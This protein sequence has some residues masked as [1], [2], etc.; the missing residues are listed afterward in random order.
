MGLVGSLFRWDEVEEEVVIPE[1]DERKGR[2]MLKW[3]VA[4][5]MKKRR[6]CSCERSEGC[7]REEAE[8][9]CSSRTRAVVEHEAFVLREE[10]LLMLKLN[11][12]VP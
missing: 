1:F 7:L 9:G 5:M 3:L 6:M 8:E 11:C 2:R 12:Q 10:P 4:M